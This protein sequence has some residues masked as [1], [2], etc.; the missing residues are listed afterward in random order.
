MP[1]IQASMLTRIF[2]AC[3]AGVGSSVMAA[4]RLGE[5]LRGTGVRV[6]PC[7][8][9]ELPPDAELVMSHKGFAHLVRPRVPGAVVMV[10]QSFFDDPAFD[11]VVEARSHGLVLKG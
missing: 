1:E 10:F 4:T 6:I 5:R 8:L 3:D 9:D 7:A 2:V 11:A